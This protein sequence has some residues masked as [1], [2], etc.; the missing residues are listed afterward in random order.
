MASEKV[1]V[2]RQRLPTREQRVGLVKGSLLMGREMVAQVVCLGKDVGQVVR[3]AL[4][5]YVA[6]AD[7]W[8]KP[9]LGVSTTKVGDLLL[10]E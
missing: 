6:G 1:F 8:R 9:D 7:S 5:V 3:E 10:D 2:N 4:A